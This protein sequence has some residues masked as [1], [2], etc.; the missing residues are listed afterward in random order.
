MFLEDYV[1]DKGQ[2]LMF[3]D[4]R[5]R[6]LGEIKIGFD[7]AFGVSF[8]WE[9]G[10]CWIPCNF[11]TVVTD[12]RTITETDGGVVCDGISNTSRALLRAG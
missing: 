10:Y 4:E 9:V 6:C 3:K 5:F 7:H 1:T 2:H 8:T 11:Q 12:G